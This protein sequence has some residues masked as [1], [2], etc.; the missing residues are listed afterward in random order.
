MRNH[1]RNHVV[2]RSVLA[3]ALFTSLLLS[4]TSAQAIVAINTLITATSGSG[5]ISSDQLSVTGVAQGDTVTV[6]I[7]VDNTDRDE[8]LQIFSTLFIDDQTVVDINPGLSGSVNILQGDGFGAT[9]LIA[10]GSPEQKAGQPVGNI[11]GLA[12]GSNNGGTTN[13]PGP[14]VAVQAVFDVVGDVTGS[15]AT[16]TSLFQ[17]NDSAVANGQTNDPSSSPDFDFSDPLVITVP[18][19]ASVLS[20]LAALAAV[21]MAVTVRRRAN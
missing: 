3:I 12:H 11:I 15:T 19:P 21:G 6:Q 8:L 5:T 14:D 17:G 1:I 10:L 16:I 4:A 2:D 13:A 9:V 18:E 20:S 7:S